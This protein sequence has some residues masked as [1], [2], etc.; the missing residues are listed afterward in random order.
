MHLEDAPDPLLLVLGRVE[1]RAAGRELAR[2]DAEVG[3]LAHVGVAHD[4]ERERRERLVVGGVTR[5][6]IVALDLGAD[7]RLDVDRARQ[8]VD[9][10]VEQGLYALVLERGAAE[11]R[12]DR[13]RDGGGAEGVAEVLGG[14][15]L[16][17]HVLLEHDLVELADDVD[18]LVAPGLGVADHVG[19]DVDGLEAL[20]HA[21]FPHE[22]LH[23]EQV[24][25]AL[26][27][28]LGADRQLHE[29]HR[30][31]EAVLDHVDTAV[32]VGADAV[33][34]VDEAHPRHVVLVGLAPHRLGLGLHA[35]DGVEHRD[36]A[37]EHA[38]GPLHL[39][40]EVHVAR[41]VDDVDPGVA[42]LAGG[43][44]ARDRDAALLLLD[45]P[46]HDGGTLVHL[47]D[48][49]G[50]AG[51]V[52]DALGRGGLPRV[53]VGHDP[54]VAD[55]RQGHVTNQRAALALVIGHQSD[56]RRSSNRGGNDA[57]NERAQSGSR[58]VRPRGRSHAHGAPRVGMD[59]RPD[60][61]LT[62]GSARTPC[63]TRPSSASRPCA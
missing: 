34:L 9:H 63:S 10:G 29:R 49:V 32:E 15:L 27:V 11:D 7:D 42:P 13:S 19:G 2:V 6:R 22:R 36:G 44:G 25:D 33:H 20:A 8:V 1:H 24:D 51:V 46:V 47:A 37:V 18:E 12:H 3:E 28:A 54:D 23:L 5:D 26:E 35:G 53:D 60:T 57:V 56:P 62:T 21:V 55:A 16:L 38:Q 4:L 43:R 40:G 59:Q 58:R 17:T 48:L 31:V 41:G 45:H 39:D 14:D 52:E 61:V 30:G 50:A